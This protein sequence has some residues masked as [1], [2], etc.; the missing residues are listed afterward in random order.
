[1][2]LGKVRMTDSRDIDVLL[3]ISNYCKINPIIYFL[4]RI[5][6][7]IFYNST[8]D[9]HLVLLLLLQMVSYSLKVVLI[10]ALIRMPLS[11]QQKWPITGIY[12]IIGIYLAIIHPIFSILNNRIFTIGYYIPL[13][14]LE[15]WSEWL[16]K[17]GLL[18][19]VL[20]GI[21]IYLIKIGYRIIK[22]IK[23][24]LV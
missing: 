11:H 15:Y 5:Q 14:S 21:G 24:Q 2:D 13:T 3:K 8:R 23:D 12:I 6:K 17:Y 9:F 7:I 10:V 4:M 19:I 18:A 20:A 22:S 1:M 16:W